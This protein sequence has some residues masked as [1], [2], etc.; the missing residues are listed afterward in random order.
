MSSIAHRS[1]R[2]IS[3]PRTGRELDAMPGGSSSGGRGVSSGGSSSGGSVTDHSLLTGVISTADKYSDSA[4][5]IHLTADDAKGVDRLLNLEI[6][7]STELDLKIA[8]DKNLYSALATD[9][10]IAKELEDYLDTLDTRYLRKDIDD[11]ALG[12]IEFDKNIFVNGEAALTNALIIENIYSDKDADNFKNVGFYLSSDGTGWFGDLRVKGD[13]MFAGSLSSP[14]FVSGFPNG[15]GWM[16]APYKRINAAGVEEIKYKL[17]ID[18]A[19]F[20]GN[21]RVFEFIVSQLLGENDNRIFAGMM[22]VDHYDPQTGRLYLDTDGGRLYNPFRKG[23]V[24]GVQQYQGSPTL[25]NDYNIIKQY[26][27][28]VEEAGVGDLASGEDRLDWIKF[29]NFVGDLS[30]IAR[31]DTITRL[32]NVENSTRKGIMKITTIDEFGTPYMDVIYGLKTDPLNSTKARIGNLGGLV[33]PYF[34]R[35]D[36]YGGYFENIW[37]RG[38]F[39]LENTGEDISTKFQ[40]IEGNIKSEISS[41]REEVSAKDNYLRNASF[42]SNTSSWETTN[43]MHLFSVNKT[44]LSFNKNFYS[45]KKKIAAVTNIGVRSV[46]RIKNSIIRQLNANL[47]KND[48]P[49][50]ELSDGTTTSPVFYVSFFYKAKTSGLLTAGFEDKELFV[51]EQIE[52]NETYKLKSFSGKWDGKG[53]FILKYTGDILIYSLSLTRNPLEDYKIEMS[54]RF[55]QTDEKIGL[56]GKKINT[57][58]GQIT[59]IGIEINNVTE[60]LSLYAKQSTVNELES[61]Y[62]AALL[63]LTPQKINL[64]VSQQIT[65]AVSDAN[66]YTDSLG[67]TLRSSIN[68]QAGNIS[69]VSEKVNS[70]GE[71]ISSAGWITRND[72][73]SMFATSEDIENSITVALRGIELNGNTT[74]KKGNDSVYIFDPNNTSNVLNVNNNF[75]VTKE[76]HLISNISTIGY[77]YLAAGIIQDKDGISSMVSLADQSSDGGFIFN[78]SSNKAYIGNRLELINKGWTNNEFSVNFKTGLPGDSGSFMRTLVKIKNLPTYANLPASPGAVYNVKWDMNNQILYLDNR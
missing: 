32:D 69:A 53:D 55:E 5:D 64:M 71:T 13:A 7:E 57:I 33:T 61:R 39:I 65:N 19:T 46:L 56:Y 43:D 62:D 41:V 9:F 8:T 15:I 11:K 2:K 10:R 21:V 67:R 17:E 50:I 63:E 48:V 18:D 49:E 35:L 37:A 28:V 40:I 24:C 47:A 70:L 31:R 25:E 23:D 38:K 51:T 68:I 74:I 16:I 36:G 30:Q 12:N 58:E 54:T 4:K 45:N 52:S 1:I 60:S 42:S 76:G 34:G 6:I 72:A 26:E 66:D 20:R 22:E 73:I 3:L 77:Y 78:G 75:I 59:D 44:L 29:R 27:F 14:T